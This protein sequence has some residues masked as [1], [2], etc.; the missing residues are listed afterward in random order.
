MT[1]GRKA[2]ATVAAGALL[3][4]LAVGAVVVVRRDGPGTNVRAGGSGSGTAP[5]SPLGPTG[6]EPMAPVEDSAATTPT[7]ADTAVTTAPGL[8]PTPAATRRTPATATTASAA[9]DTGAPTAWRADDSC[10]GLHEVELATGA[11]KPVFPAVMTQLAWSPGGEYLAYVRPASGR[12]DTLVA[13]LDIATGS[14]RVLRHTSRANYGAPQWTPDGRT[15]VVVEDFTA[16]AA[17][18]SVLSIDVASGDAKAIRRTSPADPAT[19]LSLS[20]DGRRIVFGRADTSI[21]MMNADGTAER[22]VVSGIRRNGRFSWSPRSDEVAYSAP[23]SHGGVFVLAGDGTSTRRLA[24]GETDGVAWSPRGDRVA[25]TIG[26]QLSV[27]DRADGA[28]RA[29]TKGRDAGWSPDGRSL[30]FTRYGEQ[31]GTPERPDQR[32]DILVVGAD[33][34]TERL[35]V[36]D[37]GARIVPP[38]VWSP[39]GDRLFV[40]C[41]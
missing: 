31:Q 10:R 1:R 3:L 27:V 19:H 22:E 13:L 12:Y 26:G 4:L 28:V 5:A 16:D 35:V 23:G 29:L 34:A 32:T 37:A 24:T 33:G 6:D 21:R 30:A 7:A 8:P 36:D 11:V 39:S 41:R 17:P 25:A 9:A 38:A 40:V 2:T 14:E 18:G 20:P 15:I